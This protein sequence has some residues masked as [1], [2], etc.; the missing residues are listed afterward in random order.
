MKKILTALA[1]LGALMIGTPAMAQHHGG[2]GGGM[3]GGGMHGG[4][5]FGGHGGGLKLES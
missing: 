3:G 1:I 5:G 2:G 4:G